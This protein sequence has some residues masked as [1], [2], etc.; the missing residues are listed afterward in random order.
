M[1]E[2]IKR[3][4]YI[5]MK[6]QKPMSES[7][8]VAI[9]KSG[10]RYKTGVSSSAYIKFSDFERAQEELQKNGL[11]SKAWFKEAFG[12]E[13]RKKAS[14]FTTIGAIFEIFDMVYYE[15]RTYKLNK[16]N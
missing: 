5:G 7:Q 6:F 15:K 9:D 10:F 2:K 4:I 8:I 12:E 14:N 11:I 16:C 1:V 3:S 13:A